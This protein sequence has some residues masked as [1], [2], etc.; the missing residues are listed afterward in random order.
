MRK[1]R[2]KPG[3]RYKLDVLKSLDGDEP[4]STPA[5]PKLQ[6]QPNGHRSRFARAAVLEEFGYKNARALWQSRFRDRPPRRRYRLG[7]RR[8][9]P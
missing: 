7:E 6:A 2:P 1:P 3:P 5:A 8:R 4:E 9:R